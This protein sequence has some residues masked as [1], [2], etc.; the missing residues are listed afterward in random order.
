MMRWLA[1]CL[2]L[3]ACGPPGP[4]LT[5]GGDFEPVSEFEGVPDGWSA[6]WVPATADYVDFTWDSEVA[7]GGDRSIS[8]AIA[9][10]HPE[11]PVAYNWTRTVRGW[12]VGQTYELTGWIRAENLT[13]TAWIVVQFWNLEYEE[14][15][16]FATTQGDHPVRGTRDWTKVGQVFEIPRETDEVR[17]RAGIAAPDNRGGQVWF[18]DIQVRRAR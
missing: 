5:T 17:I 16:G 2:L 14:M 15:V 11:Q 10:D 4:G 12:E 13:E 3:V 6:T 8:I 1:L 9:S 7:H 18:D